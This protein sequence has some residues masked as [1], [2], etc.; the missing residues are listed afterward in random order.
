MRILYL[1]NVASHYRKAIFLLMDKTY[2]IDYLFGKSLG[3]IK[4]MDTSLLRGKVEK[5]K[6]RRFGGGWYWQPGLVGKLFKAYDRYLLVCETRALSTWIFCLLAHLF[7]KSRK[8]YFWSHGW[9]G[10]ETGLER[11]IKKILF[12]L[13]KGGIFLY[14]NYAR[15][16]M[17]KEGFKPEKLHT[18][19]NSLD[20]DKQVELRKIINPKPI[21]KEHFGNYNPNLFFVGRLTEVKKL[22]MV[23]RA[24]SLLRDRGQQYNMTFIGDGTERESLE[25]LSTE[26]GLEQNVWF[27]GA[28]YDEKVLGEMIYNADLCVAPGNIGLTAMHTLAYGTPALTHDD[29][30]HQMPEFEAIREGETGTFFQIGS[31]ESLAGSIEN[32]FSNN[33]SRREEVRRACMREIDEQWTPE[34]QIQVLQ[35]YL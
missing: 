12:N 10:K 20:Y 30:P 26:L 28:C 15:E 16:L 17:I 33:G 3:D 2:D 8:V 5:T 29:F 18:I 35:K 34:F 9:Y 21:Y 22:D 25:A 31:D 1:D 13:P 23:L 27:Y 24:M 4:Q 11:V 19:H 32:W 14:G 7:G 6:T